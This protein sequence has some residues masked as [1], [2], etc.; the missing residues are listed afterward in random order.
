[1]SVAE[2]S[3]E[4][5]NYV[6]TTFYIE[7]YLNQFPFVFSS[8]GHLCKKPSKSGLIGHVRLTASKPFSS[9]G[10]SCLQYH[11]GALVEPSLSSSSGE[12]IWPLVVVLLKK[13]Y[14]EYLEHETMSL[15]R[16]WHD[17]VISIT[18]QTA[19]NTVSN[20]KIFV[21]WNK[22]W[23]RM[24]KVLTGSCTLIW[25]WRYPLCRLYISRLS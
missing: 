2:C 5:L 24:N 16:A 21:Q 14:G 19:S 11:A 3:F 4:M 1:M 7:I 12:G 22:G 17:Q 8:R 25:N 15:Q 6:Q 23:K 18:H 20:Q 13:S 9:D 10:V